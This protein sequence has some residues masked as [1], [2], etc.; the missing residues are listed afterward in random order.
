[1]DFPL[2]VRRKTKG[3]PS[4]NTERAD[5]WRWPHPN[6]PLRLEGRRREVLKGIQVRRVIAKRARSLS[7]AWGRRQ[8]LG[9]PAR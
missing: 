5:L 3:G 7:A 2:R 9:A 1:M 6:G 8:G 4:F